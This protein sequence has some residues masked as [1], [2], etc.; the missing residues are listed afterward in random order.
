MVELC[1]NAAA[2]RDVVLGT[3]TCTRI[4]LEYRFQVLVLVLVLEGW[5]L[6]LV[7]VL[8]TLYSYLYSYL[9]IWYY[10][11]WKGQMSCMEDH[12]QPLVHVNSHRMPAPAQILLPRRNWSYLHSTHILPELQ[13]WTRQLPSCGSI[14]RW[15]VI[16][17]L[18]TIAVAYR[19][20]KWTNK[21]WTC[22]SNL[23][24]GH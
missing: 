9:E 3:C 16:M 24:C 2:T 19:F 14:L 17:M 7:L 21:R 23:H 1:Y 22:Y 5:V 8:A 4:Q 15:T 6:V 13:W 18:L 10:L 12:Q 11:M 20:G